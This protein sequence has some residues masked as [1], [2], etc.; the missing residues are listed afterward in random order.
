MF[1]IKVNYSL[2]LI[3]KLTIFNDLYLRNL[4]KT[5]KIGEIVSVYYT[6]N[7]VGTRNLYALS[8]NFIIKR[9][10]QVAILMKHLVNIQFHI[11]QPN[12]CNNDLTLF[13]LHLYFSSFFTFILPNATINLINFP[14]F[15]F[16]VLMMIYS[17]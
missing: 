16:I 6:L 17:A 3:K 1:L 12:K 2:W 14:Y 15:L 13:F 10:K 5:A 8:L 4:T 11:G 7:F 9:R